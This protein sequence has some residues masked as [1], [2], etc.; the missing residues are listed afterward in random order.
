MYR[1]RKEWADSKTQIGAYNVFDNAKKAADD[2]KAAG[3]KVFDENGAAIY[4]P[5]TAEVKPPATPDTSGLTKIAGAARAT[6]GQMRA[7]IAK[8]NPTAPDL[9]AIFLEEGAAEGIRGDVAFAQSCLET[10][11]FGYAGSA[12]TPDQHNYCGMGVTSNGM[13]G[14]AFPTPQIGVRAQIQHLKAYANNEPLGGEI[15]DPRFAFVSRGSA[16]YV[17]WLGIQENPNGKGW[18]AGKD[19]GAK[20]LNILAAIIATDAPAVPEAPAVELDNTP[21]EWEKKAVEMAISRGIIVGDTTGNL[22]LHEAATRAD[23]L[24]LLERCGVL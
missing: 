13:K 17:E 7:Y 23:V 19:Y 5:T 6:V 12:V 20:I 24:V 8:I 1:V 3:Y 22:R 18:A 10:G 21:H 2:N 4:T 11:N 16:Q 15:V 9:A 14:N